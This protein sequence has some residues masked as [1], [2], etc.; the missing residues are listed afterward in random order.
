MVKKTLLAIPIIITAA[1]TSTILAAQDNSKPTVTVVPLAPVTPVTPVAPDFLLVPVA[2][3]APVTTVKETDNYV[4]WFADEE[5]DM[6][7]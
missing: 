1:F 6:H 7:Q 2:P 4:G 3:V 5:G